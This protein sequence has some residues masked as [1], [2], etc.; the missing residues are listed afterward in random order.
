VALSIERC[1]DARALLAAAGPLLRAE[2]ALHAR[3]LGVL[4]RLR[5]EPLDDADLRVVRR[6][7]GVV[8]AAVR[9]PP[10]PQQVSRMPEDAAVHLADLLVAEEVAVPAVIGPAGPTR[11]FAEAWSARTGAPVHLGMGMRSFACTTVV[12]P[13]RA[14]GALRRGRP[15]D[16]D[17]LARRMTAF[18][19]E[20]VP[21]DP[22]DALERLVAETLALPAEQ[23]GWWV[24]EDGEPV[25]T[26]ATVGPTPHGIRVIGVY[27]PP[28]HRGRGYAR[29]LVAALTRAELERRRLVFLST[30][31]ANPTSNRIYTAIGYRPVGDELLLRFDR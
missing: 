3:V 6:D 31:L 25:A 10:W 29:N 15:A 28:E 27:T 9:T 5:S 2:E 22:L 4:G 13:A 20:A 14:P 23:G 21:D 17:L 11:A 12:D 26:A 1:T 16:A 7:G 18:H 24:W 8:G 19:R 30:D